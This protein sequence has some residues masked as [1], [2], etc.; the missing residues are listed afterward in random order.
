M[1]A[2]AR[3]IRDVVIP[4]ARLRRA[5]RG[6]HLGPKVR[7]V[8][9]PSRVRI[10]RGTSIHGPTV[11]Y[12]SGGGGCEEHRLEIGENTYVGEFNNIRCAGAPI[13]IGSKCLISQSVTIVGTNHGTAPGVPIVDQDWN[14][15]GV[16]IGNDVWI[17]AG[18]VILPG[19]RIEDGCV[20]AAHSVVG[21]H[22]PA[23]S[24]VAGAPARIIRQR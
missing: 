7:F 3:E 19:A 23:Q 17:G 11:V 5:S 15:D 14:G 12:V 2:L 9:D 16:V 20:V 22:V 8:G 24:V 10:G 18:A 21:G 13:A 1:K 6:V 4:G